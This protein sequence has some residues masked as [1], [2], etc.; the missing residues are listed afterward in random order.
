MSDDKSIEISI[1]NRKST[2]DMNASLVKSLQT[3]E[4]PDE[5]SDYKVSVNFHHLQPVDANRNEMV[6]SFLE[7]EEAEWLL[8]IDND[9]VPPTNILEMVLHDEP[10]VSA[11]C[12]IKKGPV[13]SPTVMKEEGDSYRQININEVVDEMDEEGLI[14]VDGVGTGALLIRRDVLE[15][16]KPPWFKF[17][18]NEYGGLKLGEDFYFSRRCQQNDVPMHVDTNIITSHFKKLDLTEYANNVAEI[19]KDEIEEELDDE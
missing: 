11:V 14:E 18:Y 6:K 13:P 15:D 16:M 7:K 8:M 12:T 4:K 2:S 19:R 1:P 5:L 9:I 3:L 10:V 17:Q